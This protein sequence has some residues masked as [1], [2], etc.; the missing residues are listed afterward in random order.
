MDGSLAT[1]YTS[2]KHVVTIDGYEFAG[3]SGVNS[4][5]SARFLINSD[6]TVSRFCAGEIF[7]C[8]IKLGGSLPMHSSSK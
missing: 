1:R 3:Y 4:Y 2:S 5:H 8:S 6:H 7:K